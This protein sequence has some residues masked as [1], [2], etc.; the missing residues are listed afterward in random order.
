[1][2][3]LTKKLQDDDTSSEQSCTS[4]GKD[5]SLSKKKNKRTKKKINTSGKDATQFCQDLRKEGHFAN[6]IYQVEHPTETK[7][8]EAVSCEFIAANNSN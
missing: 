1:M 8:I 5:T 3:M 7:K 6:G 4:P 2:E